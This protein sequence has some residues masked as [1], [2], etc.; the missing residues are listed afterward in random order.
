[1]RPLRSRQAAVEARDPQQRT[2]QRLGLARARIRPPDQ[3]E[4][5]RE[6]LPRSGRR[7]CR[8][9]RRLQ[10]ASL[11]RRAGR[12]KG[13][14]RRRRQRCSRR[15]ASCN[16]TAADLANTRR[17]V[18]VEKELAAAKKLEWRSL[19][20]KPRAAFFRLICSTSLLSSQERNTHTSVTRICSVNKNAL[21]QH[22]SPYQS[23]KTCPSIK[24]PSSATVSTT[25]RVHT[26]HSTQVSLPLIP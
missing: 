3:P 5:R 14:R 24:Q 26:C 12:P 10:P 21:A 7:P 18:R 22:Q 25:T 11:A 23:W 9:P 13:D 6:C 16:V 4:C 15:A 17:A 2:G 8:A 20:N 1:M 19:K